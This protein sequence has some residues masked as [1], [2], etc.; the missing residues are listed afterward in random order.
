MMTILSSNGSQGKPD[1]SSSFLTRYRKELCSAQLRTGLLD[2]AMTLGGTHL[3]S[4]KKWNA[5]R[6]WYYAGQSD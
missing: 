5:T 2:L 4:P 6:I 1:G 3:P